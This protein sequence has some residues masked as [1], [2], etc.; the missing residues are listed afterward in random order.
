MAVVIIGKVIKIPIKTGT[1]FDLNQ[2]KVNKI[3]ETTGVALIIAR[4]SLKKFSIPLFKQERIPIEREISKEREKA[5]RLRRIV[6]KRCFLKVD[7]VN[8]KKKRLKTEKGSGKTSSESMWFARIFQN[9]IMAQRGKTIIWKK[10]LI[11]WF[12]KL[13]LFKLIIQNKI[14][15][16]E[17]FPQ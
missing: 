3:R 15:N 5:K 10:S 9:I 2:N 11:F 7:S 14:Q 16:Q 1:V 4:G 8:N 17:V 6:A 13:L 12:D